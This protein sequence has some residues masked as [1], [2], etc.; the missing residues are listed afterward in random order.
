MGKRGIRWGAVVVAAG[1]AAVCGGCRGMESW[2]RAEYQ[3]VKAAGLPE[4]EP[5][6]PAVAGAL[7][8]LPGFGDAYN[9][10]W[11]A[12][13]CNLL[14]WPISVVWGVPEAAVTASNINQQET[15]AYYY[16]GPGKAKLDAAMKRASQAPTEGP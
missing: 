2:Q 7:N 4:F 16:H 13:V 11:G 15:W 12:F 10:E 3:N 8:L 9:G 1:G 5:K 14:F 6:S